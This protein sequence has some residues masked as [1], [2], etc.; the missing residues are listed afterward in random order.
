MQSEWKT[1]VNLK[2]ARSAPLRLTLKL[3]RDINRAF[4]NRKIDF[5]LTLDRAKRASSNELREVHSQRNQSLKTI[6][7]DFDISYFS[8]IEMNVVQFQ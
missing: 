4:L 2:G 1:V 6:L 3:E 7:F 5:G 8:V